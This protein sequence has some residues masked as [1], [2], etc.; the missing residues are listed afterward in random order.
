MKLKIG[1]QESKAIPFSLGF[2]QKYF[3]FQEKIKQNV[4]KERRPWYDRFSLLLLKILIGS[5][6]I[7]IYVGYIITLQKEKNLQDNIKALEAKIAF[8][9]SMIGNYIET[10]AMKQ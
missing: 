6:I 1:Q 3:I 2:E 8:N 9:S 7:A 10:H 5:L 4:K